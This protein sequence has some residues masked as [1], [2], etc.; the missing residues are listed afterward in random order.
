MGKIISSNLNTQHR[1][2]GLIAMLLKQRE[3]LL[4]LFLNKNPET[5]GQFSLILGILKEGEHFRQLPA[6]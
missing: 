4:I 6:I 5:C 1:K 2:M 3:N